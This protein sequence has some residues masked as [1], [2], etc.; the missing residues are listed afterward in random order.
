MKLLRSI[1]STPKLG[2]IH[3]VR[4]PFM[5]KVWNTLIQTTS[6]LAIQ[7][8]RP[9]YVQPWDSPTSTYTDFSF[10]CSAREPSAWK[11][12]RLYWLVP[13]SAAAALPGHSLNEEPWNI[14]A[15]I[16]FSFCFPAGCSLHVEPSLHPLQLQLSCHVP[17]MQRT[18]GV[19]QFA[20]MSALVS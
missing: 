3:L 1:Q 10:S 5:G 11:T 13:T 20:S 4:V 15:Y 7:P 12:Q 17:T 8:R 6:A 14:P 2:S 19:Q 9:L 16:H 18:T